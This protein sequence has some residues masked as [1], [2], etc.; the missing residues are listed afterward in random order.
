VGEIA[1]ILVMYRF[2]LR[3]WIIEHWEEKIRSEQGNW[4]VEILEPAIEEIEVRGQE[5]LEAFM[6]KFFGSVGKM[7]AEAKKLD[8][9]ND[10]RKAAKTGDWMSLMVEY[11]AN[12]SGIGHLLPQDKPKTTPKPAQVIPKPRQFKP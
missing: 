11:M 8:P 10:I 2:L 5:T 9:M 1:I 12:K 7:T 4:L 3:K 6:S